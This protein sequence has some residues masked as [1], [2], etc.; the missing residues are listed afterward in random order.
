MG[1]VVLYELDGAGE[2]RMLYGTPI[3]EREAEA[4]ATRSPASAAATGP[5]A[6]PACCS[7]RRSSTT[8]ARSG[9][10]ISPV[11][12]RSSR[13]RSTGIAH[14]G[15]GE[16]E[17]LQHLEGDRYALTLQHRRLLVGVRR[18]V[19]RGTAHIR[20][21]A[22]ARRRGRARRRRPARPPLRRGERSLR[23]RRSARRPARRSSTCSPADDGRLRRR[24]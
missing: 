8:P 24:A 6:A 16:L 10:S 3:E 1:D 11:R 9:T 20:R 19:R 12:A 14:E 15:A 4:R 18:L 22:R 23:P 2:R 17:G 5:R 21:R 7:R 13:S